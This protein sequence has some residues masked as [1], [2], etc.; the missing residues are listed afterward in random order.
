MAATTV[1]NPIHWFSTLVAS[2]LG[3]AWFD[4]AGRAA[5]VF[6]KSRSV[7]KAPH[8]RGAFRRIETLFDLVEA[9]FDLVEAL[10]DLVEALFDLVEALFDLVE[11]LF[12]L[13]EALFDPDEGD[14]DGAQAGV[15]AVH[16]GVHFPDIGANLARQRDDDGY[17]GHRRRHDGGDDRDAG[18]DY[19]LRVVGHTAS[20]P[21][22][23]LERAAGCRRPAV[24]AGGRTDSCT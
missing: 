7:V 12:D 6:L 23:R 17:H 3:H 21:H 9:L 1:R 4:A 14:L 8:G 11:A 10:F 19:P 5:W 13:V 18:A 2:S 15:E 22:G 24:T 20:L 16:A